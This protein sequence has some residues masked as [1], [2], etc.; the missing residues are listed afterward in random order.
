M[1]VAAGVAFWQGWRFH[2]VHS[3]LMAF[4]AGGLALGLAV[5]HMTRKPDRPR[6]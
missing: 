3:P 2:R 6:A 1:L 4:G 5:W